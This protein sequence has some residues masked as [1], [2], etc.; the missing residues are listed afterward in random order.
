MLCALFLVP[1]HGFSQEATLAGTI[2]D[3]SGGVLPGVTITAVHTASGNNFVALT[4]ERGSYRI[5]LRIG[6]YRIRAELPGFGTATKPVA[7]QVGQT[8][9]VNLQMAVSTVQESIVVSGEAP[10]VDTASST[11]GGNIDK[12][13]MQDLPINGRN[14]MD[15]A[16]LAPGSRQNE[17]S[18]IPQ[19]RQ[20]Y[21]Q[22]NIDGQQITHLIPGTDQNQPSYSMDAIAEFVVLTNR[23][24]ATQGRSSGMLANAVTKSGTNTY[25]GTVAGYFRS[26]RFNASDFIQ[27]RVV[28]YRD[29]QVVTTF[30][31]PIRKDRIHF[32][33]NYEQE[34]QPQT[35]TFSSP[36]PA[37]NIDLPAKNRQRKGIV[38]GDVQ[39][40]SRTHLMTRF[41]KY[42]NDLPN[43]GTGGATSHPSTARREQRHS[44]E[45]FSTL[46][47]VLGVRAVNEIKGGAS[48]FNYTRD[49]AITWQGGC[50]PDAPVRCGGSETISLRGYSIGQAVGQDQ[51]QNNYSI[52]DDFT[53]S[54]DKR[55]RQDVKFGGEYMRQ[56]TIILWCATCT[57]S[58][59]ATNGPVPANIQ[60]LFPVWND[61]STWNLTALS[62]ISRRF[63]MNVSNTRF[64]YNIPQDLY[65][66]WLQDDWKVGNR[67][68]L[69]LGVRYDVQVGANSEGYVF[70]PWINNDIPHDLN[71]FGPR[72][73]FAYTLN[74]KTVIRGGYGLFYAQASTDEGHQTAE[75]VH[76]AA[77]EALYDGRADF[78]V[79]PYNGA[80]PTYAQV[81]AN[82]CDQN[83]NAVGCYRRS[84][85]D[86]INSK[87]RRM[88]Y[89][90]QG[91]I[92]FERQIATDMAVQ[93]NYVYTG[94]RGEEVDTNINLLYNPA[95][96]VNY[97]SSDVSH[98]PFQDWA[99]VP[100]G[101]LEGY[102]N[103]K[104]LET[105]FNKR[106]SHHWQAEGTYTFSYFRD[107]SDQPQ[108]YAIVNGSLARAPY[109]FTIAPDIYGGYGL[110]VTD[111]R[112]R[113]V[114]N[115]IYSP[116][117]G[118]QVSGLYFYGSG[119]RFATKY[120]SDVRDVG[121]NLMA[122][123]RLRPN[124][125]IIPRNNFVGLPLHRVDMRVQ[126]S[127]ALGR[128]SISG[129]LDVFNLFNRANYGFYTL[130]E[131]SASYGN[132]SYNSNLAYQ[133]RMLQFG[134]RL[135]F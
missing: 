13:Q 38:R 54:F 97:P 78:A 21:S 134:F 47:Q 25:A 58:L 103:Y 100:L 41:Q 67:L 42:Y 79:N 131:T 26:D 114:V 105:S 18:N 109:G 65:A 56:G 64:H 29:E 101:L 98:R 93:A 57:G 73:G 112:H 108:Q 31:G 115:G 76:Q 102:S 19:A 92:G 10:L 87:W 121:F 37:F 44:N 88:P 20:G 30:G 130:T 75:A 126:K 4:D 95:T 55:G 23:F 120:G 83:G 82:A 32:F 107:G 49:A 5:P 119:S 59:D 6:D 90:F 123:Q 53:F 62:P 74:E 7:I 2:T 1:R 125:T 48:L 27:Q 118:I 85:T 50:F 104:G 113:A 63:T 66:A 9:V 70:K 110:A 69:N 133:A 12:R 124:G 45:L 77:A 127:L 43:S 117:L 129:I 86:E 132:P 8:A 28:P 15:L 135:A 71:N 3:S 36:Y 51:T 128:R 94:G 116:G 68:T 24:D 91:S 96:G 39:F 14:W 34:R 111:Q 16:M 46:T 99:I 84:I 40:S 89:A 81:M 72:F 11:L 122:T 61:A 60:A 106:L 22:I 35:V 33:A 52:R 17:S 80:M